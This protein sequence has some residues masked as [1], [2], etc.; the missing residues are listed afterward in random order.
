LITDSAIAAVATADPELAPRLKH[1]W[2]TRYR[3]YRAFSW[4]WLWRRTV[5]FGA[6]SVA[7]GL[8][9]VFIK[10]S[11]IG[12]WRISLQEFLVGVGALLM[13]FV[14]GPLLA[15]W[16]RSRRWG[17]S[18]ENAGI[19]LALLAGALAFVAY[20]EWIER[21]FQINVLAPREVAAKLL[22]EKAAAEVYGQG[23][24]DN[25]GPG[26]VQVGGPAWR[27]VYDMVLCLLFGGGMALPTFFGEK[28]YLL[29]QARQRQLDELRL[30]VSR[31]DMQ[32]MVL[33]AQIEPHFLFNTLASLRSFIHDDTSKAVTMVDALVEHL[34]ATIP[35][36][37]EG[38]GTSTLAQQLAI[39]R[40]YLEVMKLRMSGRLEYTIEVPAILHDAQFPP[41]MLLTLVENAIKH[42][43][44][45]SP[46][47]GLIRIVARDEGG[48]MTLSV[49]DTGVGFTPGS[50]A[51][52][53]LSNLRARLA[54][55]FGERGSL[56]LENNALG[57]VTATIA[58]PLA[59]G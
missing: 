35:Q 59:P 57:G 9:S 32:L 33:Q 10:L 46:D 37:R 41:L 38:R 17:D 19:A 30:Q 25:V 1:G 5:L 6:I 13:C 31:A 20:I 58:L 11:D 27:A 39:C 55:Q 52:T 2:L 49:A 7:L 50:G 16:V 18:R 42:G 44:N 53:G 48:Q 24:H 21:P 14:P 15:C 36:M 51:G 8:L 45:P 54:A 47:G 23:G 3:D 26:A 56:A 34:R 40:S 29:E 43:L 22:T 28:R 4:P 12:D